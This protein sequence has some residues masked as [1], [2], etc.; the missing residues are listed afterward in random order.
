MV[1]DDTT[2]VLCADGSVQAIG[3]KGPIPPALVTDSATTC[4]YRE[5]FNRTIVRFA[6]Q[7]YR[8]LL[9]TYKDMSM[10][11]FEKLRKDHRDFEKEKD[12]ECLEC[13][14]VAI[15]LFGIQDPLRDTIEGSIA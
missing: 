5:Q 14:L 11:E 9:I 3:D 2:H 6:E 7:A 1:F 15:G 8:T 13:D 10:A 4:S 12:R